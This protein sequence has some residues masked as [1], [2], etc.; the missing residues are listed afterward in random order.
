MLIVIHV[1]FRFISLILFSF[2]AFFISYFSLFCCI[3]RWSQFL[4]LLHLTRLGM[5]APAERKT[6]YF[7]QETLL[8]NHTKMES[9][10]N[11]SKRKFNALI[12]LSFLM[13]PVAVKAKQK[14]TNHFQ[15]LKQT[16]KN[17]AMNPVESF[18]LLLM[19]QIS[20]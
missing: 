17:K 8:N 7:K 9:N 18:F 5:Q 6:K 3:I 19:P 15:T 13:C 10:C 2:S 16:T 20:I 14:M 4:W 1:I 11:A 12:F